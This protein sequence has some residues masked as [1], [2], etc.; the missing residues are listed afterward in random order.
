MAHRYASQVEAYLAEAV[1]VPAPWTQ[2]GR[3]PARRAAS[4]GEYRQS[5]RNLEMRAV[6]RARSP[7]LQYAVRPRPACRSAA[8]FNVSVGCGYSGA[9][10]GLIAPCG[11]RG[12]PQDKRRPRAPPTALS[13][14]Q[15]SAAARG[16]R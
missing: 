3:K 4:A 13:S 5:A 2:D 16:P 8:P 14:I 11:G 7:A 10:D 12:L 6:P 1:A 15:D 9:D